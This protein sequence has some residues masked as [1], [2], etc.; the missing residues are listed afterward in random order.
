MLTLFEIRT[1]LS[2]LLSQWPEG[3]AASH[4]NARHAWLGAL[5]GANTNAE[6]RT[7]FESAAREAG[8]LQQN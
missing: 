4:A 1:R 8:I 3:K 2:P 5:A 6:A 7:A